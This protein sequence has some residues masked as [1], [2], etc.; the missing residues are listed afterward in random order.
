[1]VI[2]DWILLL[3]SNSASLPACSIAASLSSSGSSI[4]GE[5]D[6]TIATAVIAKINTT[7]MTNN[8]IPHPGITTPNC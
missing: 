3:T 1:L 2:I 6:L 4:L 7:R 8:A 5:T